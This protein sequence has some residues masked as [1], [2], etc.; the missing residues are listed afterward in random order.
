MGLSG[1]LE[2][3]IIIPKT[4]DVKSPAVKEKQ[5]NTYRQAEVFMIASVIAIRNFFS[6]KAVFLI[7]IN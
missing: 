3:S 5:K 1:Y 4:N 6:H 7:S 2:L